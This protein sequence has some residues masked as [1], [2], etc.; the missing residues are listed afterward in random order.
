MECPSC[1]SENKEDAAFCMS[2]GVPLPDVPFSQLA[3]DEEVRPR[4]APPLA[5]PSAATGAGAGPIPR[6]REEQGGQPGAGGAEAISPTGAEKTAAQEPT[7][8]MSADAGIVPKTSPPVGDRAAAPGSQVISPGGFV[9][10]APAPGAR[11]APPSPPTTPPSAPAASEEPPV[12]AATTPTETPQAPPTPAAPIQTPPTPVAAG[13]QSVVEDAG[14]QAEAPREPEYYIPPEADIGAVIPG[15]EATPRVEPRSEEEVPAAATVPPSLESTQVVAPVVAAA[16]VRGRET[17]VVCP[18]CYA[19]NS[20]GNS[21]C[22][23]CGS[24]LPVTSTRQAAA[25]RSMPA[26]QGPQQTAVLAPQIAPVAGAQSAYAGPLPRVERAR[27][28]RSFGVADVLAVVAVGATAVAIA[29]SFS[30]AS[31]TWKKGVDI[32][33]FSHQGAYTQGRADL[34]GGPG[35][36]PY[37]GA[38][39]FTVGLVVAAGLALALIF[40]V[41][42]VGRGPMYILSGCILLFPVAY[43]FFQ[44]ILPLRQMGIDIGSAVGLR[45]IFFGDTANAGVG[46]PLWIILGSALLFIVAGLMAPPR[47]WGRL[48]TFGLCFSIVLGIAF[49]C[50]AC[51]NWNLFISQSAAATINPFPQL[52]GMPFFSLALLL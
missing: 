4:P 47:G 8:A 3:K 22:Q 17:K 24:A 45:G 46:P 7:M 48:L 28:D 6:T 27:G 11:E 52:D 37:E 50:A 38:E 18:E 43:L 13:M 14:G 5:Q 31:F 10:G 20:P 26:Q 30:L 33:M 9:F 34:L 21:F 23:E 36:L 16:A 35:I 42:R 19:P 12:V 41:V 40:L 39:F 1:S 25:A 29:L 15:V 51:F 44:A 2:C 49:F 32:G